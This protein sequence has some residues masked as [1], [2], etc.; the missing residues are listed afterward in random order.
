MSPG[1]FFNLQGVS[2]KSGACH[3][4]NN[5][6]RKVR[7]LVSGKDVWQ[8]CDQGS[9]SSEGA[10]LMIKWSVCC[11][12]PVDAYQNKMPNNPCAFPL[13]PQRNDKINGLTFQQPFFDHVGLLNV[14]D[15]S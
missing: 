9:L 15:H 7:K 10:P 12:A 3:A 4:A 8:M 2:T 13:D 5:V 11:C 1:N 14:S 6:T